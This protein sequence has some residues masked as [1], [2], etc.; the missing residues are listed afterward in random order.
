MIGLRSRRRDQGT[1]LL[2]VITL[3]ALMCVFMTWSAHSLFALKS[4]LKLMEK[5]Q[6]KR[7]ENAVA[8]ERQTQ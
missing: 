5:K 3:L 8:T 2:V 4:D 1:V 7:F 6:L